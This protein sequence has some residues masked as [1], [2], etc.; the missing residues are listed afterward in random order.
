[1]IMN[2]KRFEYD[3][4]DNIIYDNQEGDDYYF[5]NKP[6]EIKDFIKLLNKNEEY[7]Q[8]KYKSLSNAYTK[9]LKLNIEQDQ[10]IRQLK[11][12]LEKKNEKSLNNKKFDDG[13]CCNLCGNLETEYHDLDSCG[14]WISKTRCS[15][16][17]D[18]NETDGT[19]CEDYY[20]GE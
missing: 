15:A 16:G 5:L 14:T 10:E 3:E 18:L 9:Q 11:K 7:W 1:M 8:E 19:Q 6:Q 2:E 17:H 12:E 20:D 4:K 13:R